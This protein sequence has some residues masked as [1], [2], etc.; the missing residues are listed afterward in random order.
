MHKR[1]FRRRSYILHHQA[2][3]RMCD[4]NY[5]S[6]PLMGIRLE[7]VINMD[8]TCAYFSRLLATQL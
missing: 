2:S 1:Q 5:R 3:E 8:G 7:Q 4:K 6:A